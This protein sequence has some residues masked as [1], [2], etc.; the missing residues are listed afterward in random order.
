MMTPDNAKGVIC[1]DLDGVLLLRDHAHPGDWHAELNEI[2]AGELYKRFEGGD[3][4]WQQALRGQTDLHASLAS[5][6]ADMHLPPRIVKRA[7]RI[8]HGRSSRCNHDLMEMLPAFKSAGWH[9]VVA[10]NQDV[11]RAAAIRAYAWLDDVIDFWGFSCNFGHAKPE[12]GFYTTLLE[13]AGLTHLPAI[14]IDDMAENLIEPKKLG[15]QTHHFSTLENA[16]DFLAS[17]L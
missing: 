9:N 5:L 8:W 12:R 3:P 15:W 10:S 4:R 6:A 7:L 16:G 11:H 17:L 14:M 2:G 1:W 13:Q